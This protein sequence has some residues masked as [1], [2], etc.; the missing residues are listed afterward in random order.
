MANEYR[1]TK[2]N[3]RVLATNDSTPIKVFAFRVEVWR[4]PTDAP[5]ASSG[6]KMLIV[7]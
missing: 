3:L 7:S 1:T 2:A 4:T 5:V 6:R